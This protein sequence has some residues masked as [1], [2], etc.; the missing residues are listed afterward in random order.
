MKK[1]PVRC[2]KSFLAALASIFDPIGFLSPIVLH[3]KILLQA[4]WMSNLTWDERLPSHIQSKVDEWILAIKR[5][6]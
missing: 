1:K 5:L 3:G 4:M 2:K 6:D